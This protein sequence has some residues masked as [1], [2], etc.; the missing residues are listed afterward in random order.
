MNLENIRKDLENFVSGE[1]LVL[2][3]LTYH[4]K[5]ETL[6]V[7]LDNDM[8]M[9]KL[10]EVSSLV[11]N[12]LDKYEKE[13]PDNYILD[14]HSVGAERPIRNEDELKAAIGKYIY[15]KTSENEYLG[16]LLDYTDG[17]IH[18]E[19]MDKTRKINVSVDYSKTKKVRYA[20][21]F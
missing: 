7:T 8:N 16:T 3:D 20:V 9:E 13:F 18:M 6:E 21:K 11:S 5:D 1:G 14:V 2:F 4:S 19:C 12:F 10:E 17:I 15:A